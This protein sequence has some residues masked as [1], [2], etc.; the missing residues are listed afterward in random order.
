MYFTIL[1][2]I[3]NVR[4][5]RVKAVNLKECLNRLKLQ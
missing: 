1:G 3:D 4:R 2:N 5:V